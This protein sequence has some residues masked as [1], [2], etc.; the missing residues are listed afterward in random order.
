MYLM[1]IQLGICLIGLYLP[2]ISHM[3][4]RL[5]L[6]PSFNSILTWHVDYLSSASDSPLQ[7]L[8]SSYMDS[9]CYNWMGDLFHV[10]SL[11][12]PFVLYRTK[13]LIHS[14]LVHSIQLRRPCNNPSRIRVLRSMFWPSSNA[15]SE[16]VIPS[17]HSL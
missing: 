4:V 15:L 17:F 12:P 11:L 1:A 10:D 14:L 9:S 2:S 5:F 13:C 8:F 6:S 16:Y 7:A 3:Y